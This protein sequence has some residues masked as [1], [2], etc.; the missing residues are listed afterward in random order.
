MRSRKDER[1]GGDGL[2]YSERAGFLTGKA[3]AIAEWS[4][5]KRKEVD[6]RL[7]AVLRV[8]R[9]RMRH[10][11][12]A[13]VLSARADARRYAKRREEIAELVRGFVFTCA[14]CATQWCR[15]PGGKRTSGTKPKYCPNGCGRKARHERA[16][17][18]LER[19]REAVRR[20][21]ST[22]RA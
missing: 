2:D 14:R 18:S 11:E 5:R 15:I 19:R 20:A 1:G 4:H 10:P 22:A 8:R 9:W 12:E 17:A 13:R 3:A 6:Q 7:Y 16:R 21:T